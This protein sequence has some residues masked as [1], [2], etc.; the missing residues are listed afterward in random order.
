MA[1]DLSRHANETRDSKLEFPDGSVLNF[2]FY[3]HYFTPRFER[4]AKTVD[5]EKDGSGTVLKGWLLPLLASWDVENTVW[6]DKTTGKQVD[7]FDPARQDE[8]VE[9]TLPVQ[10]TDEGLDVVPVKILGMILDAITASMSPGEETGSQS[11]N[12]SA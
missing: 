9:N 4:A 10:I 8:F 12:G 7:R 2:T 6:V 3:P 11:S 1:F 5:V